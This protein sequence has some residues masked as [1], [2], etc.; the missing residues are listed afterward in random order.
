MKLKLLILFSLV[1]FSNL[2]SA[3]VAE[4]FPN[5][6]M[7][8]THK[9]KG[10]L[11]FSGSSNSTDYE[12]CVTDGSIQGT[13]IIKNLY[14]QFSSN[15]QFVFSTNEHLYFTT[16]TD[17]LT[18]WRTDGTD[19]GTIALVNYGIIESVG[20]FIECNGEV[21]FTKKILLN[22][23]YKGASLVKTNGT[24]SGTKTVKEL[25]QFFTISNINNLI[26]YNDKLYFNASI[27]D[28]NNKLWTSD[29]TENGTFI[30]KE[31]GQN[32]NIYL[33]NFSII[34]SR[35]YFNVID[36]I[37]NTSTFWSSDGT[38]QN[39]KSIGSIPFGTI[40]SSKLKNDE[41]FFIS[42]NKIDSWTYY[43]LWKINS[44]DNKITMI[45]KLDG[46]KYIDYIY[47]SKGIFSLVE[48]N[49]KLYFM[50]DDGLKSSEIWESD[51]TSIGT[52]CVSDINN[53][54]PSYPNS[55][56]EFNGKMY[57]L[58]ISCCVPMVRGDQIYFEV[59]NYD[60]DT[61][62]RVIGLPTSVNWSFLNIYNDKLYM[63]ANSGGQT[64]T[65]SPNST[66]T[67]FEPNIK[68]PIIY[69]NP[70]TNVLNFKVEEDVESVEILDL[71]GRIVINVTS[72]NNSIDVSA[73]PNGVY[74]ARFKSDKEII[75]SKF[76]KN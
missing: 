19:T 75:T 63:N 22:G 74:L 5:F 48:F 57:F 2:L 12:L 64:Y 13:K 50:A 38:I 29:G 56:I 69:P 34:G 61:T 18:L 24:I 71:T 40:I 26:K 54:G 44:S 42:V 28:N 47:F 11:Y 1:A 72:L 43:I 66:Y 70:C 27:V 31:F 68:S 39:T 51:G 15:P 36:L 9:F 16:K 76:I 37:N 17:F 14:L 58:A 60:G 46:F 53:N 35:F 10:L 73:L 67:N 52:K 49:N 65:I 7:K 62:S 23:N 4:V 21:Y 32:D 6:K 41:F 25:A 45:K 30:V 33:N 3:Q 20:N 59:W 55:F 8:D